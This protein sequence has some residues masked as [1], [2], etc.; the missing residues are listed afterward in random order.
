MKK[1]WEDEKEDEKNYY[2]MNGQK[3]PHKLGNLYLHRTDI[4]S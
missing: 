1:G 4:W 2:E 3:H